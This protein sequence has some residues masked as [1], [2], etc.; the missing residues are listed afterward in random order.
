MNSLFPSN[1]KHGTIFQQQN[2]VLYQYDITIKAW[3]KL[4]SDNFSLTLAT[5]TNNGAMSANDLQKLNRLVLPALSTSIVGTDCIAPY[6]SGHI[7][8]KS[9]DDFVKIEGNAVIQN[10]DY[11]GE[12][13]AESVPYQI[14]QHTYGFNFGIDVANL[15]DELTK[16]GQLNLSGK[17]G[18]IGQ[19]GDKGDP[20][21]NGI[22]SGPQ[23]D[24]GA[25]GVAPES[26]ISVVPETFQAQAKAGLRQAL[27]NARI[28]VDPTDET[29]YKIEFD[30]QVVGNEN[31]AASEFYI[32][33]VDSTWVLAVL[34]SDAS[35]S[36][37]ATLN[38]GIL[39]GGV[40]GTNLYDIYYLDVGPIIEAIKS[41]FESEVERLKAGYEEITAFWVNAMSDLFDEQKDALSCAYEKCLSM[42]K[43]SGERKHMESVAASILGRGK[44]DLHGRNSNQSVKLSS[45]RTLSNIQQPDVCKGGPVFPQQPASFAQAA[46]KANAEN[47]TAYSIMID[48]LAHSA[49]SNPAKL[50]LP[51]GEYVAIIKESTAS[52]AGHHRGNVKINY[53]QGNEHKSVEF[54]DKGSFNALADAQAA[55]EGLSVEFK[56]DGGYAYFYLPS[57]LPRQ[58]NGH[59]LLEIIPLVPSENVVVSA[60]KADSKIK[61]RENENAEPKNAAGVTN[62]PA[63]EH[64]LD[65]IKNE[66]PFMQCDIPAS[67]LGWYESG[68]RE[69]VGCGMIVNVAGI[70]YILIKRGIGDDESCGGGESSSAVHM[71]CFL[72]IIGHPTIAYPTFDGV[73][74]APYPSATMLSFMYDEEFNDIVATKILNEDYRNPIGDPKNMRHLSFQLR[75]I[76]TPVN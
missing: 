20:G 47:I 69:G 35:A 5:S 63:P 11:K 38:C 2:G 68:W 45:T 4:A 16:R 26:S 46:A 13:V 29:A 15:M 23:G 66:N 22:L 52:I 73:N 31:A 44:M 54:L 75:N 7:E 59:V 3:L 12:L 72:D 67:T 37:K 18:P 32:K 19:Q 61:D 17:K 9:G 21:L 10:V 6:K 65:S 51:A 14:H 42:T 33:Q 74:F 27:V 49:S 60:S 8:L 34:A 71:K 55:Y 41:K 57:L 30:R 76:V 43:S 56:H 39:G 58:A 36:N 50:E 70:D 28:I 1:P 25:Q 64:L 40:N 48:P 53:T 24:R 62:K